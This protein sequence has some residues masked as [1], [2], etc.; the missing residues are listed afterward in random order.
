MR[1]NPANYYE[2]LSFGLGTDKK[3]FQTF[4]DKF[5]SK[6][7]DPQTNGFVWDSQI[8]LDYTYEQ[9]IASTNV[10]TL[11][12]YVDAESEA[13]DKS[14]GNF[15]LGTNKIP[16][17]KHRYGLNT[18]MLRERMLMVQK[19]GEAA[20]NTE[21]KN[22]ILDLLF[23]STDKL[24]AGNRNALTHQRMQIV[25]TGKFELAAANNARGIKGISFDFGVKVEPALTNTARWWTN[26]SHIKTNEGSA[27]DP[28]QF[29]K[30]KIK[31]Y[32]H[33]GYPA[34]QIEMSQELFDDLLT[35]SKVLSRI[36]SALYPNATDPEAYA[37]NLA[38]DALK[39]NL[40]R[41]V[42]APIVVNDTYAMQEVFDSSAKAL[43]TQRVENFKATN[44]AFVP[45]GQIGTIKATQPIVFADD[46]TVRYAW[47]DGNRT[48]ISQRFDAKTRATYVESEMAVLCVPYMPQYMAVCT[49]TV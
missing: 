47:F 9:L 7:N 34:M 18:H 39:A 32:R 14:L 6:Y 25:S 19:F 16:T 40:E 49:V 23:D 45:Q 46:P 13:L 30:D 3:A 48:L 35:H 31:E 33:A 15:T 4:V 29:M 36:G 1:N 44:V 8:Q 27:S 5:A 41:L 26:A 12:V 24:L 42:G 2:L 43:K 37:K 21:A 17:M 38:D 11:P 10:A 20:L 22:A 28:V